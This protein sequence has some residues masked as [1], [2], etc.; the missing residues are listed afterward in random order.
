MGFYQLNDV[1]LCLGGTG[2]PIIVPSF[3]DRL[4][5]IAIE[6]KECIG[7]AKTAGYISID[8]TREW[9]WNETGEFSS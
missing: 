4:I 5:G 1:L 6:N 7:D 2:G 3:P 9:I 8:L